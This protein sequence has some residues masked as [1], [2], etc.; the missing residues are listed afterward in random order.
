MFCKRSRGLVENFFFFN[1]EPRKSTRSERLYQ[2]RQSGTSTGRNHF[3]FSSRP[4]PSADTIAGTGSSAPLK[5][6]STSIISKT[7][8]P[9]VQTEKSL[10]LPPPATL[11]RLSFTTRRTVC[12][13]ASSPRLAPCARTA[14]PPTR[15]LRVTACA[16]TER[17]TH[18]NFKTRTRGL[19][20]HKK[21]SESTVQRVRLG[22]LGLSVDSAKPLVG[23]KISKVRDVLNTGCWW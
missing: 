5:L 9:V 21:M 3:G 22:P 20:N 18:R 4:V 8:S 1:N 11:S 23:V 6:S 7:E 2:P 10:M 14:N 17:P 12:S 16:R 15:R 13:L 19:S